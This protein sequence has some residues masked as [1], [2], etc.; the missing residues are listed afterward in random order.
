MQFK[1]GRQE[2]SHE[3]LR[4][5]VEGMQESETGKLGKEREANETA[6]KVTEIFHCFGGIIKTSVHC[7]NCN[8]KSITTERYYDM[9]IVRTCN[10][11]L[12]VPEIEFSGT[13]TE[14]LLR[15]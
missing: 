2:D 12:G 1:L 14:Q 7:L 10:L 11:S 5:L 8:Y 3:F 6:I 13:G 4:Y 9:S 15:S